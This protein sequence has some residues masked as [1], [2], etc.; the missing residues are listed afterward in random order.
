MWKAKIR[1]WSQLHTCKNC[2][3]FSTSVRQL[4]V[5]HIGKTWCLNVK[6]SKYFFQKTNDLVLSLSP[7]YLAVILWAVG[8]KIS[9]LRNTQYVT[10]YNWNDLID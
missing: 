10:V 6:V 7:N 4:H 8:P 3:A 1:M 2:Q 5:M 9:V